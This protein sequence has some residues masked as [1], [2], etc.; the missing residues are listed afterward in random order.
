MMSDAATYPYPDGTAPTPI[1]INQHII[2]TYALG[3]EDSVSALGEDNG[4]ELMLYT[5]D[6]LTNY[7]SVAT[8]AGI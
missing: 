6:T 3:S 8:T 1:T 5:S 4:L 2:E 7:L